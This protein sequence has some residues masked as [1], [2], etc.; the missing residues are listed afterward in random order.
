LICSERIPFSPQENKERNRQ[1]SPL[2][3]LFVQL[4][5]DN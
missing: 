1:E 3:A 2:V 5:I 4:I